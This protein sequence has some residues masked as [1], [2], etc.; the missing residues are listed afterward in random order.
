MSLA[1]RAVT[2][3]AF[4][5]VTICPARRVEPRGQ[6]LERRLVA[7]VRDVIQPCDFLH[8]SFLQWAAIRVSAAIVA[9]SPGSQ[10]PD[11]LP[12]PASV[13]Q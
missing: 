4:R 1:R 10:G 11:R 8:T 6:V 7:L 13:R 9:A 2:S 5:D 3:A 12:M